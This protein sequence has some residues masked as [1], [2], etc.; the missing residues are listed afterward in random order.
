M[1]AQPAVV[2]RPEFSVWDYRVSN[3]DCVDAQSPSLATLLDGGIRDYP[4]RGDDDL[5]F[6]A[7]VA[8]AGG[9]CALAALLCLSL[10]LSVV[11]AL[12]AFATTPEQSAC[13]VDT[14]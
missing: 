3:A 1:A 13:Q 10:R 6:A 12:V 8:T 9:K 2:L 4:N 7:A 5:W 14:R 11:S